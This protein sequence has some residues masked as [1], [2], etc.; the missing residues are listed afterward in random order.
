MPVIFLLLNK[1]IYFTE[2]QNFLAK[3]IGAW[4]R[5]SLVL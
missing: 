2:S 4:R 3:S 5:K 1:F